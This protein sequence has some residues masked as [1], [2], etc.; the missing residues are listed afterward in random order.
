M[1]NNDSS[2]K[3][4]NLIQILQTTWKNFHSIINTLKNQKL[5][6]LK[7]IDLLSELPFYKEL[8]VIKTDPAFRGISWEKDPINQLEASKSSIKDLFGNLLNETKGFKYQITLIVN[9]KEYK[10]EE[11]EFTLVSF[12][13]TTKTM[14]NRKLG[15]GKS[16]QEIL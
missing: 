1:Y 8:N 14:I 13:S 9:W 3:K 10:L 7:I 12:S 15:L 4:K 16:F 6:H 11:I 2:K 5:K